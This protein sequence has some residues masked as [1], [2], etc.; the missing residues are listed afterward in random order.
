MCPSADH[1]SPTPFLRSRRVLLL[2]VLCGV[3]AFAQS[4]ARTCPPQLG[5]GG[6]CTN[7]GLCPKGEICCQAC[8]QPDCGRVCYVGDECPP[9]A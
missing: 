1:P 4:L 9:F 7:T 2:A 8:G 5:T 6:D 3:L